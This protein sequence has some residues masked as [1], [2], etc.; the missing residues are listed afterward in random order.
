M[1]IRVLDLRKDNELISLSETKQ[2]SLTGGSIGKEDYQSSLNAYAEGRANIS[3]TG[4]VVTFVT[5]SKGDPLFSYKDWS[6]PLGGPGATSFLVNGDAVTRVPNP[7]N[8]LDPGI[9]GNTL[10]SQGK[11]ET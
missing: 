11:S 6:D 3:S 5:N 10:D 2:R 7:P 4:N 9:L 8:I 1:T